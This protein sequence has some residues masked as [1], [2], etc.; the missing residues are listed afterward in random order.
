MH[1]FKKDTLLYSLRADAHALG[2][3]L[4]EPCCKII[5]T[6]ASVSLPPVGGL[7]TARSEAFDVDEFV[8]VSAAYTR[9]SGQQHAD[10]AVSILVTAVVEGLSILEVVEAERIVAQLSI[11]VSKAGGPIQVSTAGS[12]FDGLKLA[13]HPRHVRLNAQLQELGDPGLATTHVAEIGHTQATMV[14]DGFQG[15]QGSEWAQA[16]SAW[17]KKGKSQKPPAKALCSLV[18][19]FDGSGPKSCG[20]VVDIP[21]FGRFI[22]GELLVSADSAQL[23]SV[24]AELGCPVKGKVGINCVGG[25]GHGDN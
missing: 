16:R 23:V 1:T 10:G 2:G 7:A 14:A 13:G 11:S 19:G 8:R 17:M 20:H 4:E 12:R 22:F 3:F 21:G 6:L 24:R 9:V 15:H 25:G 5:P 18:D